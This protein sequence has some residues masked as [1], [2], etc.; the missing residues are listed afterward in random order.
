MNNLK[1]KGSDHAPAPSPQTASPS[2]KDF[3]CPHG[4]QWYARCLRCEAAQH[5]P[6]CGSLPPSQ[7]L[8]HRDARDDG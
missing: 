7:D 3:Y 2:R 6:T 1:Q 5:G 8:Q 4:I